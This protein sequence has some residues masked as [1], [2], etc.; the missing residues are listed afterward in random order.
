MKIHLTRRRLAL[1]KLNRAKFE[2]LLAIE[3]D[4]PIS[5]FTRERE[6]ERLIPVCFALLYAVLL[7]VAIAARN[8]G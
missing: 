7:V 3:A 8:T 2:V 1:C 4:L 5:P 6:A